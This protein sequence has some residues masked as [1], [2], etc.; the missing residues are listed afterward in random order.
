[1]S[2]DDEIAN[3]AMALA[4]LYKRA[5]KSS[6]D[7]VCA[8]VEHYAKA[9]G[10]SQDVADILVLELAKHIK[11]RP[12]GRA[13][14]YLDHF[15]FGDG[16]AMEFDCAVLLREDAGVRERVR[17]EVR[18][19]LSANPALATQRMTGGPFTVWIRQ[20]DFALPDWHLALG[21]FPMNW[22]PISSR[23]GADTG[24]MCRS[25][26]GVDWLDTGTSA[27]TR[28][29]S[30]TERITRLAI[31]RK[32]RVAGANEYKWHPTVERVTQC[33][34]QAADR[35]TKSQVKS[36][37]FWM[38]GRPCIVNLDTGLPE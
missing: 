1:M 36:Q 18:R 27:R 28:H 5:Y 11:M 23:P 17:S 38:V 24:T 6:I 9:E 16:T 33:L 25:G 22:Q 20:H 31:P 34:H 8:A 30:P 32:A 7:M 12:E 10:V 35:L 3:S 19:R 14:K 13:A 21:S 4:D 2:S 29:L 26:A 15:L 37:T